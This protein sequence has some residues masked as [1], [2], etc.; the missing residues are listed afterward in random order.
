MIGSRF[1]MRF[2]HYDGLGANEV[3]V[4]LRALEHEAGR[5]SDLGWVSEAMF[6]PTFVLVTMAREERMRGYAA[7]VRSGGTVHLQRLVTAADP[8]LDQTQLGAALGAAVRR[9]AGHPP[10]RSLSVAEE[11]DGLPLLGRLGWQVVTGAVNGVVNDTDATTPIAS[12]NV[13]TLRRMPR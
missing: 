13:L 10:Y 3:V 2:A 6:D 1:A 12:P 4:D 11:F 8:D 7:A 9:V 5:P